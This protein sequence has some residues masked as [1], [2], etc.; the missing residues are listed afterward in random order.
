MFRKLTFRR[1]ADGFVEPIDETTGEPIAAVR[2]CEVRSIFGEMTRM[3]ITVEINDRPN[4]E[5][6]P[7]PPPSVPID[8]AGQ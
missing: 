8:R 6:L 1:H 4:R 3:T 5:P 2:D 7:L